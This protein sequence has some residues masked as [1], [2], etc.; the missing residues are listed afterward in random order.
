[1]YLGL[2]LGTSSVKAVV[3]DDGA[4]V[5]EASEPLTVSRPGPR[6]SE[7]APDDWWGAVER[8]M[9]KLRDHGPAVDAI[10]LS[11]QM[12][13][14]VLL[15]AR[16]RVLRDAILWN[17]GRSE[18]ECAA[19][20][21]R[22]DVP[23]LTGNRAMPGFTAPKLLWI[24]RNEP[25]AFARTRTVLLP[26]D[27]LRLR[28]TGE[29]A[30]DL[31]DASGTLWLDVGARGW[32]DGMLAATELNDA[33]MPR[34]VEGPETTGVLRPELAAEWGMRSVPVVGGGGDQA[35]GA[36]GVGAVAAGASFISLGTSGVYFV[37]DSTYRPN[38]QGGVHAFCHA[39]PEMW[40]QM[41]VILSAASA[42]TWVAGLTGAASEEALIDEVQ[43]AGSDPGPL[44]FLPYLSGERTPHNDANAL[45]AFVGLDHDVDRAR[46]GYTVLE[47]VAFALADGQRVLLEAGADLG[48]ISVIGGGSQSL[49][50]GRLLSA[51]LRR[52][53]VY[54]EDA[55]VGPALGAAR[56]AELG[57][58]GGDPVDVC[59]QAPVV[60]T[61]EASTAEMDRAQERFAVYR[62][63]YEDLKARFP[64][65]HGTA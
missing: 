2:D 6:M 1:M 33:N 59:P 26:K 49:Y 9:A 28:M 27:Y 47:G 50:W 21:E 54:R 44:Y 56:L 7:Q 58:A 18:A 37:P 63:L 22:V 25:E 36:V 51:A 14:A 32:S 23:A 64:S 20:E 65:L 10:G 60:D 61:V 35:A 41:S 3:T 5:A 38:P 16:E 29:L 43:S 19:L 13:G 45:G 55:A 24:R 62:G 4:V 12:H 31:S 8:V 15:D 34:L 17:D 48:E 40:H 57:H 42:L 46:L 52:P 30:T 11:G 39:L 53:M